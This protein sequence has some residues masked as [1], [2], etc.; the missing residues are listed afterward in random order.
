MQNIKS[1]LTIV[2][3][4]LVTLQFGWVSNANADD[5]GSCIN[6]AYL[7]TNW[8]ECKEEFQECLEDIDGARDAYKNRYDI[9]DWIQE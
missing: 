3:L 6:P 2:A 4:V 5:D 7:A 1:I 8:E 9:I